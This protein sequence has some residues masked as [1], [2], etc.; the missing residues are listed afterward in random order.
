MFIHFQSNEHRQSVDGQWRMLI[1]G[2]ERPSTD[3][4]SR[5]IRS[6]SAC[7]PTRSYFCFN[8][9]GYGMLRIVVV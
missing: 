2:S 5:L 4:S 3:S 6:P 8:V 1:G 7:M 9:A